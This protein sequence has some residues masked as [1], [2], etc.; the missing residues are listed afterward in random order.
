MADN[1]LEYG[2]Q[3]REMCDITN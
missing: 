1:G 2:N 3:A